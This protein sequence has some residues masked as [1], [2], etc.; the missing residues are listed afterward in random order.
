LKQKETVKIEYVST[1]K[2]AYDDR[3]CDKASDSD[4]DVPMTPDNVF[5]KNA[6]LYGRGGIDRAP[7]V[8]DRSKVMQN[9]PTQSNTS[10]QDHRANNDEHQS[11]QSTASETRRPGVKRPHDE[12]DQL[13]PSPVL[14]HQSQP[15]VIE[16]RPSAA[17]EER[18]TRDQEIRNE[19][20]KLEQTPLRQLAEA[21]PKTVQ[22]V[23]QLAENDNNILH[24]G[25]LLSRLSFP[26]STVDKLL[27][28][29]N[30]GGSTSTWQWIDNRSDHRAFQSGNRKEF[31][32]TLC[33]VETAIFLF[34]KC[35]HQGTL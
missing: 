1:T 16:E 29:K 14:R 27:E 17:T 19:M 7:E 10:K 12:M 4:S 34:G 11:T 24:Q 28:L 35:G 13:Q 30:F 32:R 22:R 33:T 9:Q 2:P 31:Y 8:L 15:S 26:S 20:D 25:S 6:V 21:L 23:R 3:T 5:E 18:I